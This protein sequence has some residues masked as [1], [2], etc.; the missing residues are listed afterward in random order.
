MLILKVFKNGVAFTGGLRHKA[1]CGFGT[2]RAMVSLYGSSIAFGL[3]RFAS[4]TYTSS[5]RERGIFSY[6]SVSMEIWFFF[7]ISPTDFP[8]KQMKDKSNR[9]LSDSNHRV[10][11]IRICLC[12][13][14]NRYLNF[15]LCA[16]A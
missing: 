13:Y 9:D 4:D 8:I 14:I 1:L 10:I 6:A 2:R 11:D 3:K 7:R 5:V 15:S 16:L 12:S